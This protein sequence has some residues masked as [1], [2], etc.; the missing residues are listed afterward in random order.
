M[1]FAFLGRPGLQSTLKVST[2]GKLSTLHEERVIKV[3]SMTK[4]ELVL[5]MS[6]TPKNFEGLGIG[7]S[8]DHIEKQHGA[9][10]A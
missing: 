3:A 7:D 5:R 9:Q 10:F 6:A 4:L 8:N 2:S 1:F